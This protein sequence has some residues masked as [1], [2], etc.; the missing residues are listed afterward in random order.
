MNK[1]LLL[2][3]G[4]H[5][6]MMIHAD[7]VQ[8][9]LLIKTFQKPVENLLVSSDK[10]PLKK[11]TSFFINRKKHRPSW[12][13]IDKEKMRKIL[14]SFAD[15]MQCFFNIVQEPENK[16]KAAV[17]VAANIAAMF[18]NFLKAGTVIVEKTDILIDSDKQA[19]RALLTTIDV[20][21]TKEICTIITRNNK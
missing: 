14:L 18:F 12:R 16:Q 1:Q 2:I 8:K 19:V 9:T 10:T 21:P 11:S 7:T 13:D 17:S 3:I 20:P 4:L 15:V 6:V 5:C